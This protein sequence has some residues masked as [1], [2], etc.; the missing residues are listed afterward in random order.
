[1]AK[2][3]GEL[4]KEE[5]STLEDAILYAEGKGEKQTGEAKA[6]LDRV[7]RF[8]EQGTWS[9]AERELSRGENIKTMPWFLEF[10]QKRVE[11][12]KGKG[13]ERLSSSGR[14]HDDGLCGKYGHEMVQIRMSNVRW[15]YQ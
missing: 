11:A 5:I 2:N 13:G 9:S 15:F 4:L 1:M 3:R 6:L 8:F 10:M 7:K 12:R 14:F